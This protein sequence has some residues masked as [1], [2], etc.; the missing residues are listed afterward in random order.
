MLSPERLEQ[1]KANKH[2]LPPEV[3]AKLGELI[4]ARE[5]LETYDKGTRQLHDVYQ[6]RLA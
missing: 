2:L 5:D 4:S 1:I 6:L 3:R